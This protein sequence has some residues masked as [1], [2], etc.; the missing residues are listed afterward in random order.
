MIV[1]LPRTLNAPTLAKRNAVTLE[2]YH[3]ERGFK[4][5]LDLL[6]G[7]DVDHMA[8]GRGFDF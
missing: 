8:Q 2:R 1:P 7:F 6:I 4:L 5:S 3:F